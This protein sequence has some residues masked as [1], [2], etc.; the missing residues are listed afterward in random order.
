[1]TGRVADP[2]L[3]LGSMMHGLGWRYDPQRILRALRHIEGDSFL[4][5]YGDGVA[6]VDISKLIAHH[7]KMGKLATKSADFSRKDRCVSLVYAH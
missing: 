2:A 1:M 5:T 7:R 6:D 3:F 4:A